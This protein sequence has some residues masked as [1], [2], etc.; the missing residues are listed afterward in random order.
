MASGLED[1]YLIFQQK[2]DGEIL[3]RQQMNTVTH[4]LAPVLLIRWIAGKRS[5]PGGK[6]LILIGIAGALPDLLN[7][8]L[9]LEARMA[10]WSHGLPCWMA[11]TLVLAGVSRWKSDALAPGIAAAMSLAYLFHLICD[12]ISGGIDWLHPIGS[13]AWG[14]YWVSPLLW[15]PLDVFLILA[16]YATFRALPNYRKARAK[17]RR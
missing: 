15:I 12:A 3:R 13:L 17:A 11:F 16:A 2:G 8:H 5:W 7:P 14:A 4:A 10:S 1:G 6:N 9:S